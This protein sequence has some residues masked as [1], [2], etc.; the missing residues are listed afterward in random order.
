[1]GRDTLDIFALGMGPDGRP[2]TQKATT[3]FH[4]KMNL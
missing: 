4:L 2:I 1:M 3:L